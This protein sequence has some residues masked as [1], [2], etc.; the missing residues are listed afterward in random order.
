[1]VEI[2]RESFGVIVLG[3]TVVAQTSVKRIGRKIQQ[4]KVSKT[5]EHARFV[6]DVHVA[7]GY[8]LSVVPTGAG[9]CDVVADR[10][11]VCRLHGRVVLIPQRQPGLAEFGCRNYVTRI[12]RPGS[13][14]RIHGIWIVEL[15]SRKQRGEIARLESR[16]RYRRSDGVAEA[17]PELLPTREKEHL[18]LNDRTANV[19]PILVLNIRS[20]C[21]ALAG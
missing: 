15:N 16:R 10:E 3:A 1:M 19:K 13:G 7:T 5:S 18:V 12:R 4:A 20:S 2:N 9:G 6:G 14:R 21:V 11:I 8:E 17:L